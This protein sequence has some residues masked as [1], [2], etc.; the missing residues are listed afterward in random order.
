ML[1][2][3]LSPHW[4]LALMDVATGNVQFIS[5]ATGG[6]VG[7]RPSC[8]KAGTKIVYIGPNYTTV[9][10]INTDGSGHKIRY[11]AQVTVDHPT[12][13]PD[14]TKIAFEKGA[15]PGNTEIK[16]LVDGVTKRLTF[17][18]T[19]DRNAT[20]S[21]DGSTIAFMSERSG[22]AQIWTMNAATGGSLLRITHTT[23]AERY[24]S[25]SH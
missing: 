3:W 6:I 12:F 9:E 18:T 15:I 24:P 22:T 5:P 1:T 14:G 17:S 21:P 2:L 16:N 25:W 10:Q 13:S 23:S 20:C 8:N 4:Y 7:T 11:T 19:A